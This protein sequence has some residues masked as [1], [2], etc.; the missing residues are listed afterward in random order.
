MKQIIKITKGRTVQFEDREPEG[1][2]RKLAI[3][4]ALFG[5]NGIDDGNC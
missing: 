2:G 1:L 5:E 3:E 4:E